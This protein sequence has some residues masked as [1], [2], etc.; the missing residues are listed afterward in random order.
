MEIKFNFKSFDPSEHLKNY[1]ASRFAKLEKHLRNP[2]NAS[3]RINLE[4]EKF[5]QMAEVVLD[6]D[7]IHLS[8]Q[9]ETNDMYSTID[10]ALDKIE[11]QLKKVRDKQ[12]EKRRSSPGQFAPS[13]TSG[14][15]TALESEA[16]AVVQTDMFE[17]KPMDV[18]EAVTRLQKSDYDFLVF[19]NA[20]TNRVNVVYTRKNGDFGLIDPGI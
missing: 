20:G 6:A 1:A 10:V 5:R 2:E 16:P 3:V 13:P 7:S 14:A 11:K 9:E 8:T 19:F 15:E 17:P 4:V 18:E 12:K